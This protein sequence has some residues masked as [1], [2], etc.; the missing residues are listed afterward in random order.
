MNAA[1][2]AD[3]QFAANICNELGLAL[4]FDQFTAGWQAVFVGVRPE[5]I[6]IMHQLRQRGDR[7]VILSNT[8][9]L[10]TSFWPTEYPE[11]AAGCRPRLSLAGDG[12]AQT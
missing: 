1:R 12:H 4:S 5:V 3:E 11:V 2:S 6:S 8:N 10:H 9:K 7:V